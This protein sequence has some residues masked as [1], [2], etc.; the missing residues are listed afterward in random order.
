[1]GFELGD[2]VEAL[3]ESLQ[4]VAILLELPPAIHLHE[5]QELHAGGADRM[6]G[7]RRGSDKPAPHKLACTKA[8]KEMK[9]T[10]QN[11]SASTCGMDSKKVRRAGEAA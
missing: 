7:W 8:T 9:F 4:I 1:M 10:T 2:R 5:R 3:H 11:Q 6:G